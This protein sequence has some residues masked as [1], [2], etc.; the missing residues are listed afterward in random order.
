METV[1][2]ISQ[3]KIK[4]Y[5][6]TTLPNKRSQLIPAF[7]RDTGTEILSLIQKG[8]VKELE[9]EINFANDS[10]M[11]EWAYV[12][13]LDNE[14]LEIYQGFNKSPLKEE[15]RFYKKDQKPKISCKE[16]EYEDKYYPIKLLAKLPFKEADNQLEKLIEEVNKEEE[17]E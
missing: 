11:C 7:H 17:E 3:E 6:D 15:E 13:D 9:N 16:T 10:L 12:L 5:W 4:K 8:I 1:K 2:F 14:I